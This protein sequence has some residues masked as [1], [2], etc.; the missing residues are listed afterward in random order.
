MYIKLISYVLKTYFKNYMVCSRTHA[1]SD[2]ATEIVANSTALRQQ[3]ANLT[4]EQRDIEA[5]TNQ[6]N[7]LVEGIENT[8]NQVSRTY[9]CFCI[10]SFQLVTITKQ[11][12]MVECT[13]DFDSL[14]PRLSTHTALI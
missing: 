11:L 3:I 12:P 10:D 1:H 13:I 2:L 14:I 6:T 4:A 9:D 7:S 8:F 5:S